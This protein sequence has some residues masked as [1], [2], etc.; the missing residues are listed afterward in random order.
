MVPPSASPTA[1]GG[2]VPAGL[3]CARRGSDEILHRRRAQRDAHLVR[4]LLQRIEQEAVLDHVR[5]RLARLDVAGEGE[6]DRTHGVFDAAVGHRPCRG[7]AAP[8]R[9]ALPNA[10]RLEQPPRRRDDR[11][12]ALVAIV[13]FAQASDRPP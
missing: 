12:G 9:G 13:A 1:D 8:L 2:A 4:L 3:H 10:E 7:S 11:R 5:E 6:E